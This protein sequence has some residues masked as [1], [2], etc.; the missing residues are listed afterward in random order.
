MASLM[1]KFKIDA[2]SAP[3]HT[4]FMQKKSKKN[5]RQ[6][7]QPPSQTPPPGERDTR[8]RTHPLGAST[9]VPSAFRP[10]INIS[11]YATE[12]GGNATFSREGTCFPLF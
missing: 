10:P 5:S 2:P 12:W 8:S 11:G 7:A 9:F 3:E 1:I 4:I 6:G